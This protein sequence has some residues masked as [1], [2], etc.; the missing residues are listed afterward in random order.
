MIDLPHTVTPKR[1]RTLTP[2]RGTEFAG[3]CAVSQELSIP[4]YFPDP[5]A[6]QQRGTNENNNGLIR[7][8]F[9]YTSH[10]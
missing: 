6:P 2:A 1:L 3:Y 7:E 4:V 10:D 9:P 5:Y 8:Y